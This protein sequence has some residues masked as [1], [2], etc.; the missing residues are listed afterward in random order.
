MAYMAA[1]PPI[2]FMSTGINLDKEKIES[3]LISKYKQILKN[4]L[5]GRPFKE[6]KIK[7]WLNNI[8]ME[9]K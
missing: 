6:N 3:D 1:P 2:K 7:T 8:L 5:E 4:H 9:A